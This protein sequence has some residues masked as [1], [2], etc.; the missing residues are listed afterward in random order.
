VGLYLPETTDRFRE[1]V[2]LPVLGGGHFHPPSTIQYDSAL[3]AP[4]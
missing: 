2:A 1:Q 4:A 3:L